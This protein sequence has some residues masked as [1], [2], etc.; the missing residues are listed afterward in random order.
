MEFLLV[1]TSLGPGSEPARETSLHGVEAEHELDPSPRSSKT[2]LFMERAAPLEAYQH[3]GYAGDASIPSL[4]QAGGRRDRSV[5]CRDDV[6]WAVNA[7]ITRLRL[8]LH[9]QLRLT[10]NEYRSLGATVC[11]L[12][13]DV[14]VI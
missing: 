4:M 10:P 1:R 9:L 12:A 6:D 11:R 2:S 3:A 8:V 14:C 7:S 13:W 5:A